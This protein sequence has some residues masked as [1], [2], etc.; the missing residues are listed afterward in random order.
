MLR[1]LA[2]LAALFLG[3][4]GLA[5]SLCGGGFLLMSLPSFNWQLA[6]LELG[7]IAIGLLL[8]WGAFRLVERADKP[9]GA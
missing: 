4:I 3:L 7:S 8:I 2:V 9:P 1:V 5:M 6:L